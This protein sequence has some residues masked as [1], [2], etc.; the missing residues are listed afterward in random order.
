MTREAFERHFA[1]LTSRQRGELIKRLMVYSQRYAR[2]IYGNAC[3]FTETGEDIATQAV[4][5]IVEGR[6][7]YALRPDEQVDFF[8]LCRCARQTAVS[9]QRKYESDKH[10]A[11][12]RTLAE[13]ERDGDAASD[14]F[15]ENAAVDLLHRMERL[16]QFKDYLGR[17]PQQGMQKRYAERFIA[18]A[19]RGFSTAQIADELGIT[20]AEVR[21]YR[22]RLRE[23]V[24]EFVALLARREDP[25][26][27]AAGEGLGSAPPTE[28][29]PGKPKKKD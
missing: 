16:D 22:S 8:Y 19:R 26:S 23:A 29:P 20:E 24:H 3:N 1:E 15:T 13:P 12:A 4:G 2:R 17:L 21:T 6:D 7:G 18:Y 28:R 5:R 27:I 9:F 14:E 11:N 25:K 10:R